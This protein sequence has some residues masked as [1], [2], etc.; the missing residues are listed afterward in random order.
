MMGFHPAK[1]QYAKNR[2]RVRPESE[3][4][5]D[6]QLLRQSSSI[7]SLFFG[8]IERAIDAGQPLR[9]IFFWLQLGHAE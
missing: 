6:A 8:L 1:Q 3:T 7:T 2:S 4:A 5:N 9:F